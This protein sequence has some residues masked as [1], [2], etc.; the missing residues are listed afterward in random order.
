MKQ[1]WLLDIEVFPSLMF[2]GIRDY[3]NK[4]E[5]TFEVS[6][7]KDERKELIK[8]FSTFDGYLVTFN[9]ISYDNTVIAYIIK[10]QKRLLKLSIA[11]FLY[12]VK[13]FS[14]NVIEDNF[15]L[16]KTY[17]WWKKPWIDIDLYL[18]W[19]KSLR[20]SKKISLKSLG[21][22]LGHPEVEELPYEHT[23]VLN[24]EEMERV[25][26]Y[27]LVNDLGILELLF[28]KMKPD[29]ALRKYIQDK[30]GISSWSMDAP[31]IASEVLLDY[32]CT[33]SLPEG[34]IY[35]E[36]KKEVRNTKY[37]LFTGKISELVP[38]EMFS[39]KNKQ[40]QK[41]YEELL[42]CDRNFSMEFPLISG[43]TSMIVSIGIGG[44]HSLVEDLVVEPENENQTIYSS[45]VNSMY[46]N[47]M[48]NGKLFRYQEV[49]AKYALFKRDKEDGKKEGDK[50][51]EKL[52]KLILNSTSG[53][54][55]M[56]QSWL[57]YSEGALK[58]RILGQ[59]TMLKATD[60]C[61]SRGWKVIALNTDSI[62]VIINKSEVGDYLEVIN[63]VGNSLNLIFEHEEIKAT[64][65]KNINN[66]L[67]I[68]ALGKI[69]RKGALFKLTRD[70][71]GNSEIPLGDSVNEN[72]ICRALTAHF[73]H[74]IDIAE[75]ISSPEKYEHHIYDY[76]K[77]NK[78]DKSY[79]VLYNGSKIQNLNRY[80]FSKS[81]PFLFKKKK[82]KST[83]EHINVGEGVTIFNKYEEKPWSEY[84]INYSTYIAKA[85]KIVDSIENS[86][87][88]LK[89]F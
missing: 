61:I 46:P 25:K 29:I 67:Q 8:A 76:C 62:D 56:D 65:Y 23:R 64:Y 14:N 71:K 19:A 48:I 87:R 60:E 52:A 45:D 12:T 85:R 82:S 74:H 75:Y 50:D 39:F 2:I 66:Y 32:Y 10:E 27:N 6:E 44:I 35:D 70:E 31:K 21:I 15:E 49:L 24:K 77:S 9:G 72:I 69:K 68:S 81:S 4:K 73:V 40:L 57:Y 3:K 89:L 26:R 43:E 7:Y 88:Q 42:T 58:L 51:K 18:Y 63:N 34:R 84:N 36:Y 22:Q 80:Y 11:D 17:R 30:Y 53:L 38:H 86:K 55:D 79:E 5:I 54:L 1:T 83:L 41:V 16:I 59:L 13:E 47:W 28:E 20:I 37:L 78:I 33:N